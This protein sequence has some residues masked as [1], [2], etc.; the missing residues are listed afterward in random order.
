MCVVPKCAHQCVVSERLTL[1]DAY[2]TATLFLKVKSGVKSCLNVHNINI[3][4]HV[5]IA[6]IKYVQTHL[7][8]FIAGK[9]P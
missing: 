1:G 4:H 2:S 7:I 3:K 6:S 9:S 5:L 8:V